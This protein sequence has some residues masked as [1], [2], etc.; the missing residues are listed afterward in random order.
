M[1]G[2]KPPGSAQPK[3]RVYHSKLRRIVLRNRAHGCAV[4]SDRVSFARG[5]KKSRRDAAPTARLGSH[6]PRTT[7][8]RPQRRV[9]NLLPTIPIINLRTLPVKKP[10]TI[11]RPKRQLLSAG[12]RQMA[13]RLTRAV[14]TLNSASISVVI[15]IPPHSA[16]FRVGMSSSAYL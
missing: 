13:F 7:A 4:R 10:P 9:G 3:Q 6:R 1:C 12:Q 11:Q 2:A 16:V 5:L 8:H 15:R 14:L